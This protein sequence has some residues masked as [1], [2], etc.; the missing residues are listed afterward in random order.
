MTVPEGEQVIGSRVDQGARARIF[1]LEG[2]RAMV[3][4]PNL[5]GTYIIRRR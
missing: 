3:Y 4:V 1:S 2:L 5:E